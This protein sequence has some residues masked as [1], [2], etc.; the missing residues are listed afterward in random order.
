MAVFVLRIVLRTESLVKI[1]LTPAQWEWSR[2][3]V[4]LD[5]WFIQTSVLSAQSSVLCLR[6]ED[7]EP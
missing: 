3:Q 4:G 1:T 2:V 7:D 6:G 5:S